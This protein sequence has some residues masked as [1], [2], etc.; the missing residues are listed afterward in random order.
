MAKAKKRP[1][2]HAHV[3]QY[4]TTFLADGWHAKRIESIAGCTLG[5]MHSAALGVAAIG[6]G[7]SKAT[8]VEA[9]HAIKQVDRFLSNQ[10]ID[11]PTFFEV[12]VP[13]L[14]ASRTE[15][16]VALDWTEFDKDDQSTLALHLITRHG[17]ATPLMWSTVRKSE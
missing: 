4:V 17:R 16:V 11:V 12:W 9:K 1:L 15:A 3:L 8:G 14:L 13:H 5:V 6:K 2:G 10:G 7:L